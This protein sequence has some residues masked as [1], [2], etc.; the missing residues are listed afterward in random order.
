[1]LL[2]QVV[3]RLSG[4]SF[5]D[6]AMARLFQPLGMKHTHFRQNHGEIVKNL[7]YSYID[8]D[9]VLRLSLPNYDTFGARHWST[10]LNRSIRSYWLNS[11][12]PSRLDGGHDMERECF[13]SNLVALLGG[14]M[15]MACG[16]RSARMV[17][18]ALVARSPN[19][20]MHFAV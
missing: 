7:A 3:S 14:M 2:A 1:M 11:K 6:F 8:D 10:R 15:I 12:E 17:H 18:S 5:P 13:L 9:H 20:S 19:A 16:C 4:Q